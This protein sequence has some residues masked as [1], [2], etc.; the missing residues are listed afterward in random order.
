MLC[1]IEA[2]V[3]IRVIKILIRSNI[4]CIFHPIETAYFYRAG[5]LGGIPSALYTGGFRFE[6][7]S[8]HR[9][10]SRRFIVVLFTSSSTVL[11]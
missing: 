11:E 3:I 10:P 7:R 9:L 5:W 8:R 2:D 1:R 6:S 4:E